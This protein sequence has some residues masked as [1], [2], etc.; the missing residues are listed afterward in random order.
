SAQC[1]LPYPN[2]WFTR[3]DPTSATGRRLYLNALS[4]PRKIAGKPIDPTAWNASDG[5]SAG[6]EI[7]TVVPGMTENSD[8]GASRLPTDLNI[9]TNGGSNLGVVL[10]DATTGQVWPTWTEIDH[11]TSEAGVIPSGTTT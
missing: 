2:D 7:L 8:L 1:M 10:I 3:P 11:Y 4:M 9:E 5:F 6:S